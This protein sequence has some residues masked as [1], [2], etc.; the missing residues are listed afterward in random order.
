MAYMPQSKK[1][2][3]AA[4]LKRIMPK[5]LKYTLG[6]ENHSTIRLN[7]TQGPI[8]FFGEMLPARNLLNQEAQN[9]TK[10]RGYASVNPYWY[11]EHF[12]GKTL[13][14]LVEIFRCLNDGNHD[15][16]DIMTDYFD[17]GWYVSVNI[18]RWDRP[19]VLTV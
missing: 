11:H 5:G 15:N 7:I 10:A 6:V 2:E 13:T 4:A 18:G 3:I 16:S 8:D 19:Y 12:T 14:L 9:D 17:V 1:Q